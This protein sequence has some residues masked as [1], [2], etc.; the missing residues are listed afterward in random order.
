MA[1]STVA[2]SQHT[3]RPQTNNRKNFGRVN[4]EMEPILLLKTLTCGTRL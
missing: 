2:A 4:R 1:L 3:S